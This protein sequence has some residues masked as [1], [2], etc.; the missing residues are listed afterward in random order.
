[1]GAKALT[2][3]KIGVIKEFFSEIVLFLVKKRSYTTFLH[4]KAGASIPPETMMHFP[5]CFRFPPYFLKFFLQFDLFPTFFLVIN[6][7]FRISPP[8]SRKLFFPPTF[9]NPPLF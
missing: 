3:S 7:K 6:R 2:E 4:S 5:P 8:V 1:M 9:T